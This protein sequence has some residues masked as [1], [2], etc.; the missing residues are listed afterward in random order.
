MSS[1]YLP[2]AF[3]NT[4]SNVKPPVQPDR[5]FILEQDFVSVEGLVSLD[6]PNKLHARGVPGLGLVISS[7]TLHLQCSG[8]SFRTSFASYRL[9]HVKFRLWHRA[10][11]DRYTVYSESR[12]DCWEC[13]ESTSPFQST[14]TSI[15]SQAQVGDRCLFLET[16]VG[17]MRRREVFSHSP[18]I[19]HLSACSLF[20]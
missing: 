13:G 9:S 6:G 2:P 1:V 18:S 16:T 8:F 7:L 15:L 17:T 3:C 10:R 20:S 11:L 14:V 5:A 19:T 12:M 4:R